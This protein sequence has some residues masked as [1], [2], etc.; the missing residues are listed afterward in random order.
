[1]IDTYVGQ[2]AVEELSTRKSFA[3]LVTKLE[4]RGYTTQCLYIIMCQ[5]QKYAEAQ[6]RGGDRT[7]IPAA[8]EVNQKRDSVPSTYLR[9]VQTHNESVHPAT[10]R[11]TAVLCH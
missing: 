9:A 8:T 6:R 7:R 2:A 3:W 4:V 5:E 10:S 11:T 1:M